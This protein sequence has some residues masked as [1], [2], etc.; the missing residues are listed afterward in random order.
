MP[1]Y[2]ATSRK[3]LAEVHPDLQKVFNLVIKFWDCSILDGARSIEEQ[4]KNVAK[5][6]SQTMDSLHLPQD[7]GFSWAVDALPYPFDWEKIQRG[8]DAI[9]R[10]DGGMEIAEVYAFAGFV[11]GV[12]AAMGIN[13][14]SGYD[15]NTNRQ[16]QDQSFID[17][18]HH[19][20]RR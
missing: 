20:K 14:R 5:G 3:N 15:W 17:L 2:G 12:A 7:D 18:P 1:A 13:L 19:E 11:D 10:A 9:K 8:L 4:R 6:V 16:F